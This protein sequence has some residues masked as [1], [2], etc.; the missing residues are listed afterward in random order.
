MHVVIWTVAG[1]RYAIATRHVV[2]VVPAVAPRPMAHA[3]AWIRGLMNFR[4]RL[5][6]L[7]DAAVLMG[8]ESGEP[9]MANRILVVRVMQ[10]PD[11]NKSIG[12]LVEQVVGVDDLDFKNS[13]THPG[14]NVPDTEY[15]GSVAQTDAGMVQL[16]EPARILKPEQ[17]AVLFERN[18]AATS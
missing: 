4:G 17:A 10:K 9:R 6:P 14:L 12:L 3:T 18:G 1:Q 2:E 8:T 7:I 15:L 13:S 11:D 16:L 5:I